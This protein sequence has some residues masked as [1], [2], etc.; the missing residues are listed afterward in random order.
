MDKNTVLII[1]YVGALAAIAYGIVLIGYILR[2][3]QGSASKIW[4]GFNPNS[5]FLEHAA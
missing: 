4:T 2:Q 1:A 3:P 5:E